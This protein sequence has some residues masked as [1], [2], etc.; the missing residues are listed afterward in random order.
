MNFIAQFNLKIPCSLR[1]GFLFP[2]IAANISSFL[3]TGSMKQ[4][5]LLD[6]FFVSLIAMT[7]NCIDIFSYYFF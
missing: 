7:S 4:S 6:R 1:H 3:G 2:V 5:L